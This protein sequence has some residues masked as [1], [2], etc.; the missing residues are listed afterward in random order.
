MVV[1]STLLV[2]AN[3]LPTDGGVG[4]SDAQEAASPVTRSK[5]SIMTGMP[6]GPG[7]LHALPLKTG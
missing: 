2:S 5:I 4:E 1:D 3:V 6:T 7:L